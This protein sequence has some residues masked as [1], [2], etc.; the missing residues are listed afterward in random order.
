MGRTEKSH[1]NGSRYREGCRI[2]AIDAT[3]YHRRQVT[4]AWPADG[5]TQEFLIEPSKALIHK[6]FEEE[7]HISTR[8]LS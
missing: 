5:Q 1:E 3:T 7:A 6:S 4:Y 2:R 8:L